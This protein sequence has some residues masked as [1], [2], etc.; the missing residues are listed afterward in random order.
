M[1]L[2]ESKGDM[3]VTNVETMDDR[4]VYVEE[5][6]EMCRGE[7]KSVVFQQE[8]IILWL[9]SVYEVCTT[10]LLA[11]NWS[12]TIPGSNKSDRWNPPII[13]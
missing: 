12:Y 4:L 7:L 13:N 10:P 6:L 8:K 2:F 9:S 5:T 1:D 11:N 3:L